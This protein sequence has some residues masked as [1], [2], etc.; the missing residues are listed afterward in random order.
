MYTTRHPT[1]Y[2]TCSPHTRTSKI[3]TQDQGS[4]SVCWGDWQRFLH[5]TQR[6]KSPWS[7]RRVK[8]IVHHQTLSLHG[9]HHQMAGCITHHQHQILA[10]PVCQRSHRNP[11]TPHSTTRHWLVH[12]R[13]PA[14]HPAQEPK[15]EQT[16]HW[17]PSPD[18]GFFKHEI[19]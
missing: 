1:R 14:A 7:K 12:Q 11:K 13:H 15:Q 3:S 4:T 17:S 9:P 18:L 6:T 10:P 5:P 8:E 16:R 19:T 2:G